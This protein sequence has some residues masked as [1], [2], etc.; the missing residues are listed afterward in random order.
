VPSPDVHSTVSVLAEQDDGLQLVGRVD[1]I[2]PTE[3][4]RSV[5]FNGDVGYMVTFKKTDPLFVFDLSVPELPAIR[6]E[7]KIPGYSTYMHLMDETHVLAI[8]FD[9]DEQ[10]DFAWFQGILLQIFDVSV[11]ED[12]LLVH[13]EVIGT[14]GTSSDA[15]TNHLAFNFF[16]P[17]SLLA[18]PMVICEGGSGGQYGDRMTFNGLLVYR[19]DLENGFESLGG[20]PHATPETE[21][22]VRVSC[23]NWWTRQN[24]QV[25]RS[26]FMEDFVY[27]VALDRINISQLEDLEHPLA[28]ILLEP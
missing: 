2:A 15:A 10:G 11:L 13:R 27:S 9:S 22:E 28:S 20:V 19:V 17:R 25:K 8:G 3:D 26:I 5:R 6:G 24:S 18:L 12:P 4:I 23:R 21:G 14:R 16:R 1:N 7:L